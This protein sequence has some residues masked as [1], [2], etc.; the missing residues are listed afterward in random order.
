ME[1]RF[2]LL[3][4]AAIAI[5]LRELSGTAAQPDAVL[6][7]C[8]NSSC[9]FPD[10]DPCVE[11]TVL[12]A[13]DTRSVELQFLRDLSSCGEQEADQSITVRAYHFKQYAILNNVLYIHTCILFSPLG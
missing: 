5:G 11:Y 3:L 9:V 12:G 2:L 4:G 10:L 8:D 1:M 7:P 6:L 13:S